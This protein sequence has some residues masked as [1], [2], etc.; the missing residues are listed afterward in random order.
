MECGNEHLNGSWGGCSDHVS[1]AES[2]TWKSLSEVPPRTM[3]ELPTAAPTAVPLMFWRS[4][5]SEGISRQRFRRGS[6]ARERTDPFSFSMT[7][8]SSRPLDSE[9]RIANCPPMSGRGAV[10]CAL[11]AVM[12]KLSVPSVYRPATTAHSVHPAASRV[13]RNAADVTASR[14]LLQVLGMPL[15]RS[16]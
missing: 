16:A 15:R 10:R 3:M 6:Y 8:T 7:I 14:R 11:D 4:R 2:Y 12:M 13:L 5:A 1:W 9:A